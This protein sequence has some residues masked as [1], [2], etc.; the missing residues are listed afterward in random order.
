LE[1]VHERS[2]N[3]VE[4]FAFVGTC[5]ADRTT[6]AMIDA[7]RG[8]AYDDLAILDLAT[9]VADADQRARAHWL[10]G[11]PSDPSYLTPC[12]SPLA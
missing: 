10:L 2:K 3:P 5:C 11:L 9:A 12:M 6:W 8:E 7:S 4:S 1:G